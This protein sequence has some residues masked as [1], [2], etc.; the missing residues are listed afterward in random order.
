M[1]NQNNRNSSKP[2]RWLSLLTTP[3]VAALTLSGNALAQETISFP[4]RAFDI[5]NDAYWTVTEF[6]EGDAIM[7]LNVQRWDDNSWEGASGSS[8]NEQNY[9]WNV[10]IY[11]PAS[12]VIASCWR[13]FPDYPN[14][15][16]QTTPS[17]VF[18]GGNHVVIITDEGNAISLNH[19]KAG[20]IPSELCPPNSGS[21]QF[22]SNLDKEGDWRVAAFIEPGNRPRVVEG[23]LI[24]RV[25]N[26]GNSGGPHLHMSMHPVNGLDANG[27]E[28]IARHDQFQED[29]IPMRF[30]HAWGH[31]YSSNQPD[32]AEGWYRW[33]GGQFTDNGFKMVHA[34]PY[35]RRGDASAG[36][37]K[38]TDAVFLS[39]NRAVTAVID[40]ANNLKLI[41]WDVIGLETINRKA[42][43]SAGPVKDVQISEVAPNTILVA[44]RGQNDELKMIAY[45]VAA[46]GTFTRIAEQTA[47]TIS[48]LSMT[49]LPGTNR[50]VVTAV[51]DANGNLKLIVWDVEQSG[52][53]AASV[54]RLGD[55][56]AGAVSAIAI[57][58]ARNFNGAFTAVR[59]GDN[60]LKI[61]PWR[62][63]ADGNT[64]TRGTAGSAGA[65]SSQ[66]DVAPLGGGVAAAVRDSAGQMRLITWSVSSSGDVGS[67][68][69]TYLAGD[70][71]EI[72]LLG[73]PHS[74][75]NLTAAVRNNSGDLQLIGWAIDDDG[76]NLRRLGS[77]RAG[78]ATQ[79]SAHGISRSYPN[80]DPRDMIL[81]SLRDDEGNLK[82]I[83][84]DTNLNNP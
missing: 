24:G 48:Q 80:N 62:I 32:T 74:G 23:Q 5:P 82:L 36:G 15:G 44:V 16:S 68:R 77:S 41:S 11:A 8:T 2:S 3:L 52:R 55:A 53:G 84:W 49:T 21:T 35:L 38:D 81:T 72:N 6:S 71:S 42:D 50:K 70:V 45:H 17:N 13:N 31:A 78:T 28:D 63:S 58:H 64:V 47:G 34:S 43:I 22:P 12:G 10:P 19:L 69:E 37:V 51:K 79:I 9:D 54:V 40:S 59:D 39:G 27:R 26:N 46:G 18:G 7:D 1:S 25:G 57:S 67:R 61:I 56:S 76:T 75:S 60:N 30:R 65:V 4:A 33:R 20:S 83:T 66:I 29:A 14:P 73:T